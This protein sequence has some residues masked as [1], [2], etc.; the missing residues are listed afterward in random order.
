MEAVKTSGFLADRK[1]VWLRDVNF[2]VDNAVGKTEA[3]KTRLADLAAL[4]KA[5]FAPGVTLVIT[6]SKVDKRYAF[7]KACKECGELQE[8]SVP[9]KGYAA[10]RQAGDTLAQLLS[11]IGLQMRPE[12]QIAFLD[13]VGTDTRQMASEVE[14][15]AVFLRSRR[16]VTVADVET[17]TSAS[18]TALAWD[19]ADAVGRKELSRALTILGRLLFQRESPI[20]L[21]IAIESRLRELTIYRDALD[22]GWLVKKRG[23]DGRPG[24]GWGAVPPE[25]EAVFTGQFEKDPRATHPFRVSLLAAQAERFTV[26]DLRRCQSAVVAA[27]AALVSSTR[28]QSQV[29]ETLLV[30][31]L[32]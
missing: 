22:H 21:I 15:L 23:Y 31:M 11:D 27:H 13:R 4:I 30:K 10:A 18:R 19:L 29:L 9:D 8:F 2:L 1:V 28:P 5:G 12:V 7:Y 16:D 14:K 17:I 6:A 26:R 20:G 25:V 24:Y 3:V 32:S